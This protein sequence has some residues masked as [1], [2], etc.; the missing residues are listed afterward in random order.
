MLSNPRPQVVRRVEIPAIHSVMEGGRE[1]VLGILQE[2]RRHE[3][4]SAFLPRDFR[5]AI[6]WVHLDPGQTLET[7]VHPVDSMILI[8]RGRVLAFGDATAELG[9]GDILLV[10]HG[11]QHGFTGAGEDGFWGLSLQFNSR[12]LYEDLD[13]P[14]ARFLEQKG[15]VA[16]GAGAERAESDPVSALTAAN[17]RHLEHF[18]KHRLFTMAEKGY[19]AEETPRR[20]FFDCFQIW[21]DHFQRMLLMRNALSADPR[22]RAIAETHLAEELGHNRLLQRARQ[23]DTRL[24][25]PTLESLCAWFP[26]KMITL[27]EDERLVLIHLVVEGSALVFYQQMAPVFRTPEGRTHFDAHAQSVDNRHVQVGIDL[28]RQI[29]LR[30]PAR[31]LEI[32]Q[33]GWD[34]LASLFGR[35]A[36]LIM[37]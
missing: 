24:W 37:L 18:A 3:V 13:D 5:L 7:H 29:P 11:C 2:F 28:L 12:G 19:L 1:Q 8:T 15:P 31:L 35:I 25:D 4:L 14:W 34:V 27:A 9:E 20:R 32:Q 16:G 21:S 33:R 22:F 10:P 17:Q 36:D 26:W 30:E 23:S 6:A